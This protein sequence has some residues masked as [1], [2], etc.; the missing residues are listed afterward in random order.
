MTLNTWW[1]TP[2][3][4][5]ESTF[6]D[7]SHSIE[8]LFERQDS[9]PRRNDCAFNETRFCVFTKERL[10]FLLDPIGGT[11]EFIQRVTGSSAA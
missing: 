6:T 8:T 9:L 4:V 10:P 5:F 7:L 1:M 11:G 2:A 3:A